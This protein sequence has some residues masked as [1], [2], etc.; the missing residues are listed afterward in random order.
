MN[1][2]IILLIILNNTVIKFENNIITMLYVSTNEYVRGLFYK[3]EKF[4]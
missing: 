3:E 2:K 1:L 4:E